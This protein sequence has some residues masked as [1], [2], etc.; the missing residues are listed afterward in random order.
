MILRLVWRS[1]LHRPGRS[2]LLL[3]GYAVG[4]GVTAT[5]LSIGAALVDASRDRELTGGGDLT[6]LP[7]G[8]DLETYRTGG[9]SALHFTVEQAPF[10]YRQVLAGPRFSD[11]VEAAAPWME[12]EML[13]L[14]AGPGTGGPVG[15]DGGGQDGGE[16][17]PVSADGAIPSLSRALGGAPDLVAGSWEDH[18][19]DTLWRAPGDSALLA[20]L[21]AFHLPEGAAAGDSTWAEWHYFNVMLPDGEGWL[22]L[23]YMVAGEVPDGEWGG[24]LLA[25]LTTA[26]EE[27]AGGPTYRSRRFREDF[28]A[29]EVTFHLDRPDLRI[30]PGE[31]RLGSDGGYRLR[32]SVPREDEE[33]GSRHG[34]EDGPHDGAR[35]IL[36]VDLEVR[37]ASPRYLPPLEISPGA[38][39]SGY[40]VPVLD[41]RAAGRICVGE[42]CRRVEGA[43][44]YHDHNWGTWRNVTWDWGQAH[45]EVHSVLYGGV[46]RG[47]GPD[48]VTGGRFL[49]LADSLGFAGLW[50]LDEVKHRWPDSGGFSVVGVESADG[51]V[52]SAPCRFD[53]ERTWRAGEGPRIETTVSRGGDSLQLRVEV[54]HAKAT[55]PEDEAGAD[56]CFYQMMGDAL[57]EGR[58][59]GGTVRDSGRG[60]FETWE[61]GEVQN[62]GPVGS[63][64]GRDTLPGGGEETQTV[65][66]LNR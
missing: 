18:G 22:Y 55:P 45:M 2:V 8:L 9:V 12:D 3:L 15:P 37:A 25:T 19:A 48:A 32:A 11:R 65:Y 5:L 54:L 61:R 63:G 41:G 33:G 42:T 36:E 39:P 40:T 66:I 34:G 21:D 27:G 13:Y 29:G 17:V 57:L 59:R 20:E 35:E 14:R 30:G 46:R 64:T 58:V 6:V 49:F 43:P 7:V 10:L 1:L 26:D 60:F 52:D 31:V 44:A 38:F 53:E 47:A 16:V 23:T 24:R 51:G 28:P 62:P 56:A 4:V 50:P